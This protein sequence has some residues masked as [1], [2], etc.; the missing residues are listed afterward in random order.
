MRLYGKKLLKKRID[1]RIEA[2]RETR[3]AIVWDVFSDANNRFCRVKIQG[4]NQLITAHY[5]F[6]WGIQPEYIK[7]GNAVKI[8]HQ[9]GI[10]GKIEIIGHG[11]LVPSPVSGSS[12]P[13]VV[14]APDGVLSGMGV[15]ELPNANSMSVYIE[16]GS[17]RIS[18][19]TY[20]ASSMIMSATSDA[21]MGDSTIMGTTAGIV[22]LDASPSVGYF[23]YDLISIGTDGVID[24]QAGTPSTGEPSAPAVASG[25][26]ELATILV[27]GTQT[28]MT[29]QYINAKWQLPVL[30]VLRAS[31]SD[32]DLVWM[33]ESTSIITL[34][35]F[36]Q[37]GVPYSRSVSQGGVLYAVEFTSGNGSLSHAVSSTRSE[38]RTA[39]SSLTFTYTRDNASAD[40]SPFFKAS[41]EESYIVES[42]D[43]IFINLYDSLGEYMA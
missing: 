22:T 7:P 40:I 16:I 8:N 37:Y 14:T 29:N 20:S 19:T 39:S 30:S 32:E 43:S 36:D 24:Y 26:I 21:V 15:K 9:G 25:H 35:A 18:G 34:S 6:N 31:V 41:V 3:D 5:P 17:Y 42:Y 13:T 38:F 12:S 33:S 11:Q 4:S 2:K 27:Y 23:R 28:V 1:K 10:R